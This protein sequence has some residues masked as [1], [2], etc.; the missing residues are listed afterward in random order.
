MTSDEVR[1]HRE[2][3][4]EDIREKK[5]KEDREREESMKRRREEAEEELMRPVREARGWSTPKIQWAE[6]AM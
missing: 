6:N 2:M 3:L 4:R 5:R 1:T